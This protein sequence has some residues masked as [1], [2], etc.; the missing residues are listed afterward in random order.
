MQGEI[1][2][3]E[4]D[5]FRSSNAVEEDLIRDKVIGSLMLHN[6]LIKIST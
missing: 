2:I 6:R 5:I 3:L 4:F 1:K